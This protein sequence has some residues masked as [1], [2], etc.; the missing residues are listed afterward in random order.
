MSTFHPFFAKLK[1][2]LHIA[3]RGGALL[4]PENTL[5]AFRSAVDT[6]RT[7]M[8]ELDVHLSK[9]GELM[10]IH[11]ATVDRCTDGTDAIADLTVAELEKLDAG[12]RFT[13]D[14]KTF[15]FR[16]Q[17]V[18]IPTL[19]EVLRAFP[20]LPLNLDVKNDVRDVEHALAGVLREENALG[21]VTIGSEDDALA[22]RLA[23]A[24]P[25]ACVFYPREA[26]TDYVLTAKQGGIPEP[27]ERFAVLDMP[28]YLQGF[29]LIDPM[30][31]EVARTQGKWVNVWVV[32]DPLEMRKLRMEGVGGIM[33][34]RPDLLRQV[35]D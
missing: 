8:L 3:H 25:G 6:W 12:Y 33:T 20:G 13:T 16:G 7:N 15:P 23:R 18:R 29:R 24:M 4:A 17:G 30:F 22:D 35:L 11:D 28:L 2:T 34:D 26:L 31:L 21:H 14:G 10:V 1:P 19:R 9:D 32:D 27:D 5:V